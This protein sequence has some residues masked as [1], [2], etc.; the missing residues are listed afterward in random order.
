MPFRL[1]T[2]DIFLEAHSPG[3]AR[4]NKVVEAV[5]IVAGVVAFGSGMATFGSCM[6][7]LDEPSAGLAGLFLFQGLIFGA[8]V[9]T[10]LVGGRKLRGRFPS[11][12][13]VEIDRHPVR[14]GETI[15]GIVEGAEGEVRLD[16]CRFEETVVSGDQDSEVTERYVEVETHPI[17]NTHPF[18][19]TVPPGDVP[20]F[21]CGNGEIWWA[22]RVRAIV[23][24][25]T[26]EMSYDLLVIP[27]EAPPRDPSPNASGD[28]LDVRVV[29]E[30]A[31]PGQDVEITVSVVDVGSCDEVDGV[32]E[33]GWSLDGSLSGKDACVARERFH[34]K[35]GP[36]GWP[37]HSMTVHMPDGPPTFQGKLFRVRWLV[38][39][40]VSQGLF[41]GGFEVAREIHMA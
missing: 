36:D 25:E 4:R 3:R 7:L 37:T 38:R 2:R 24:D 8:S 22:I 28:H 32:V 14:P 15:Q 41:K 13:I 12:P 40:R 39:A 35:G 10:A 16:L 26:V 27:S 20:S 6:G 1:V 31:R 33:L 5:V 21:R 11:T 23:G 29:P 18:L 34:L 9:T 19:V 30:V 17:P